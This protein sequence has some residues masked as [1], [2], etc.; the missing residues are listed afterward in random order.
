[1]NPQEY[2]A[3]VGG[4]SPVGEEFVYDA[5]FVKLREV[6]VGFKLPLSL[7]ENTPFKK[8]SFSVIGRNLWI[9]HKNTPGFDPEAAFNAG[10]SQGIEAYAFP[11]TRSV[12][13]NLNLEL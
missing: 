3:H 13:F 5:S 6:I 7:L 4:Q 10:N 8:A 12:G 1:M 11:S 9:I 2:W